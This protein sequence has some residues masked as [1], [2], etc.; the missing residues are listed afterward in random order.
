[1]TLFRSKTPEE[2]EQELR[3]KIEAEIQRVHKR[4]IKIWMNTNLVINRLYDKLLYLY[5]PNNLKWDRRPLGERARKWADKQVLN[6]RYYRSHPEKLKS[7]EDLLNIDSRYFKKNNKHY[8]ECMTLVN[9]L[10]KF[11][12]LRYHLKQVREQDEKR[13]KDKHL[14]KAKK[15]YRDILTDM[16]AHKLRVHI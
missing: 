7:K 8:L 3:Q 1:M 15:H 12:K 11:I 4:R 2:K 5:I 9:R 6:M 13:L 16:G 10:F 14:E